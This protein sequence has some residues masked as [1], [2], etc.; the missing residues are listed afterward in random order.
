M[1]KKG[2]SRNFFSRYGISLLATAA[3]VTILLIKHLDFPLYY[4]LISIPNGLKK[5]TPFVDLHDILLAGACWRHGVNVYAPSACLE[6]GVF[7]YSPFL[8][9]A[10]YLPIGPRDTVTGG[11]LLCLTFFYALSWLPSPKSKAEFLY[12]LVCT[13][14]T[15]VVYALEQGNFDI[16]IFSLA[17]LGVFMTLKAGKYGLW[18][19]AIFVIAAAMKFYPVAFLLLILRERAAKFLSIVLL[20]AVA[21][22]VFLGF[23]AHDAATAIKIIP[24]SAP[25]R[26]TFGRIDLAMGLNL[27]HLLTA[28]RVNHLLGHDV[29]ATGQSVAVATSYLMSLGALTAAVFTARHYVKPLKSLPTARL[30]FLVAGASVVIFCFFLAQNVYYRAVFLLFTL[31]GLWSLASG[32]MRRARL[33]L[34]ALL[35]LLWETLPRDIL[36][37]LAK[38]SPND[39]TFVL[40]IAF[41]LFRECLWWWVIIQLAGL[42]LAFVTGEYSRLI[43]EITPG[44][45]QKIDETALTP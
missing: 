14:S 35:I 26:A 6:G 3:F 10:A 1:V 37:E 4:F 12:V 44:R 34:A 15:T 9:R 20:S 45:S 38:I 22:V 7:N 25:F 2:F 8:L 19:Y 33:L 17:A 30:A 21:G 18:G 5:P 29:F 13:F 11:F 39:A 40:Q 23:F 32:Q 28:T 16:V 27:L 43:R 41:W 42:V 31:P 36:T 24:G